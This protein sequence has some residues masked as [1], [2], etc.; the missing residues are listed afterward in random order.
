MWHK[1][2][3]ED[4]S[5]CSLY[6]ADCVSFTERSVMENF[7]KN[8]S[9]QILPLTSEMERGGVCTWSEHIIS[10]LFIDVRETISWKKW[11][12]KNIDYFFKCDVTNK[13][14]LTK[15]ENLQE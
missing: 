13:M 8:I 4:G 14:V 6:H 9:S 12:C 3:R 2:D 15:G 11:P 10:Y 5:C 1:R 7:V